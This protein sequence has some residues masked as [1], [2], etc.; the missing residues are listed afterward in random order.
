MDREWLRWWTSTP[1]SCRCLINYSPNHHHILPPNQGYVLH[2]VFLVLTCFFCWEVFWLNSAVL[3]IT[4]VCFFM[5]CILFLGFGKVGLFLGHA[6]VSLNRFWKWTFGCTA[7]IFCMFHQLYWSLGWEGAFLKIKRQNM[8]FHT[9]NLEEHLCI[10]KHEKWH[11][12]YHL[13]G[14]LNS[15]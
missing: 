11:K 9:E 1:S 10:R 13:H 4:F 8:T 2:Y 12:L 6:V 5:Y 14:K 15:K 7:N 3:G